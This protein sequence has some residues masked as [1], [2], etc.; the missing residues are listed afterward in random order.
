MT[1]ETEERRTERNAL[2]EMEER[3]NRRMTDANS[4]NMARFA[5]M[6]AYYRARDAEMY[7]RM[8]TLVRLEV[9]EECRR[10]EEAREAARWK[11][12]KEALPILIGIAVAA[13]AIIAGL[14]L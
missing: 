8:L 5:E 10:R 12:L 4:D 6:R 9:R 11:G 13:A 1:Q 14:V 3:V 7:D 2:R